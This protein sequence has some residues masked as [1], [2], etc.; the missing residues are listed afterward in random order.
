[1]HGEPIE[2]DDEY[3]IGLWDLMKRENISFVPSTVDLFRVT[4]TDQDYLL[5]PKVFRTFPGGHFE[6]RT[7][8][9]GIFKRVEWEEQR[10]WRYRLRSYPFNIKEIKNINRLS[11]RRELFLEKLRTRQER[12][13]I[14]LPLKEEAFEDLQ[15]LCSPL[16]SPDSKKELNEILAKY[17]PDSVVVDSKL[18]IRI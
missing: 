18:R 11:N 9:L 2:R 7:K 8:D 3:N 13:F 1:M 17:A 15:I 4:Y 14:D 6:I 12:E 16:M 5:K 10:E